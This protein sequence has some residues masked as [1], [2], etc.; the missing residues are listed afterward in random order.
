MN[1]FLPL[2]DTLRFC[3][4]SDERGPCEALARW[5]CHPGGNLTVEICVCDEHKNEVEKQQQEEV[6]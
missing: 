4:V 6:A 5:I 1:L 2:V 3:E